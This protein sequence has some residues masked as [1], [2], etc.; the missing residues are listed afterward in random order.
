MQSRNQRRSTL[1]ALA[2]LIA[3]LIIAGG[4]TW[5]RSRE[6]VV[7]PVWDQKSYVM[8]ADA[9][10]LEINAGKITNP[11]NI[12]PSSRPPGTILITAPTGPLKDFRNFYFRSAFVPV[13]LMVLAVFLAGFG[14]TKLAWPSALMAII[15]G[16]LPMFWQ[17]EVGEIHNTGYSWGLMDTFQAGLSAMA[18][19]GLLVAAVG[20]SR[21]WTVPALIA[22]SL[23]PVVK[24]SGFV[25][26]GL[27]SL[28]WLIM[29]I[30]F[31]GTANRK[32]KGRWI[33]ILSTSMM[34]IGVLGG[35]GLASLHSDYFST[36]NI[37]F[38]KTA[39]AQ[40]RSEWMRS[41]MMGDFVMLFTRSI[42]LPLIVSFFLL[43]GAVFLRRTIV[44]ADNDWKSQAKWAALSGVVILL[45]GLGLTYQATLFR[46]T[47]YFFPVLATS[48]VLLAPLLISWCWRAGARVCGFLLLIPSS[49]LLYLA[50]PRL[51]N[52]AYELGSYGLFSG[53]GKLESDT[54]KQWLDQFLEKET[55]LPILFTTTDGPSSAAVEAVFAQRLKEGGASDEAILGSITRPFDWEKGG[56]VRISD[57]YNADLLVIDGTTRT[58]AKKRSHQINSSKPF[59]AKPLDYKEELQ[60]WKTWLA[61]SPISGSTTVTLETPQLI[62]LQT[63]DRSLLYQQMRKF[64]ASRSWRPEFVAANEPSEFSPTEISPSREQGQLLT[65]PVVFDN[66]LSLHGLAITRDNQQSPEITISVYSKSRNKET[67]KRMQPSGRTFGLFIHQLDPRGKILT[68]Q[69]IPLRSSR[70][71]KRP[72]TYAKASLLLLPDT[73]H[74]G[75][76]VF[77]PSANFILPTD[78]V[79]AQGQHPP[80]ERAGDAESG[81]WRG[82]RASFAVESIQTNYNS[83]KKP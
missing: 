75:V 30:R 46:Q 54:T 3:W 5:K 11:L 61:A 42:G 23:V 72:I 35:L 47:R 83:A 71:T 63:R 14:V 76:G 7:P 74:L 22:L 81:Y 57:I 33:G 31:S 4:L 51:S 1:T 44:I 66:V 21:W 39:L 43:G 17:F 26:A 12:P 15:A 69:I 67:S 58:A 53:F 8:K 28:A 59:L 50:S 38:G 34:M 77:V 73:T 24:P 10:W 29:A 45:L 80:A 25:L 16:S 19:A 13:V 56:V 20:G 36:D 18:M 65:K 60:A 62:A 52:L 78:W 6:S 27:I 79:A 68:S 32:R 2:L 70:I 37:E 64:I 82:R 48:T 41:E 40:L 9:F 49:L 55:Q